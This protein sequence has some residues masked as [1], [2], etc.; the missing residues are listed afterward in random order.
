MLDGQEYITPEVIRTPRRPF[1]PTK[2]AFLSWRRGPGMQRICHVLSP[3][4]PILAPGEKI[5]RAII[6]YICTPRE[7]AAHRAGKDPDVTRLNVL[8]GE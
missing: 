4:I 7:R 5:T 2:S 3:G 1:T 8:K 6:D